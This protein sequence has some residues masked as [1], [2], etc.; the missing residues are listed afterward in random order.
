MFFCFKLF[1]LSVYG[2]IF[3]VILSNVNKRLKSKSSTYEREKVTQL[4]LMWQT[5]SIKNNSNPS[6][7]NSPDKEEVWSNTPSFSIVSRM[8]SGS[9]LEYYNIFSISYLLFWPIKSWTNSDLILIFDDESEKDHRLG[10]ILANL[11]PYPI[12]YFE[13]RPEQQTFCSD[14][15]R[16]GYSRQQYSNF[17]SDMYTN[18]EYIGLVDSDSYLITHVTPEDLIINGKPR[19]NGYNGCCKSFSGI[20]FIL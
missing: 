4:E 8:Y 20:F 6:I 12:V 13:K 14:F 9:V 10:T 2:I 1:I 5:K 16:E 17:Y 3:L 19:I 7:S 18:A 11:P 15:Q